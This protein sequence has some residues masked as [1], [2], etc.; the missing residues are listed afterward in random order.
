MVTPTLAPTLPETL[1]YLAARSPTAPVTFPSSGE[2]ITRGELAEAARAGSVALAAAGVRPG[3]RVGILSANTP[4]FLVALFSISRAGAA[5]CPLPLPTSARDLAGYAARLS[6]TIAVADIRRV[7]VGTSV[8]RIAG[9]LAE[10]FA[11][12][13]L[14]EARHLAATSG[15]GATSVGAPSVGEPRVDADDVA[16]VQF[17]SGSTSTP[18]GVVLTHRNVMH[19]IA[20]IATGI[21]LDEGEH[22][23]IWLP[24]FHD[25]GLFGALSAMFS[26]ARTTVWGPATFVK[27]P[28]GWLRDFLA[29]GCTVSPAPNFGYD[30]LLA[31]IPAHEVPSLDMSRWR[32][33]LNGAETIP[34][35]AV[36]RFLDHFAPAGFRPGAMFPVYGMAEATLAVTFPPLGRAPVTLWVDRERLAGRGVVVDVARDDARA[37]GVVALGHPVLGM[38]LRVVVE[39]GHGYVENR[40]GEIEIRGDSVTAGYLTAG[41]GMGFDGGWVPTGDLGFVRG[42]ELFITGRQKEMIIVRGANFYPEDAESVIRDAPGLHRRRCIAVADVGPDGDENIAILGETA[43]EAPADRARLAGELRSTVVA[44][45]GLADVTVHLVAP[46]ALPR[47]SSGKFQRVAAAALVR[48]PRTS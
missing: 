1:D 37:R 45:L 14:L 7:V 32:V 34:A 41:G 40:V 26:Q 22:A 17:T 15:V 21:A 4:D 18:K 46:G 47:T 27:D 43:L 35:A 12:V 33:A 36:E 42:N 28:A 9:R 13:D 5:A 24:L 16:V 31:A 20:A 2:V 30:S 29:R 25:M 8:A 38:S 44:A 10:H 6:R 39:G 11:G 19:G 48:S 23:G 3:D